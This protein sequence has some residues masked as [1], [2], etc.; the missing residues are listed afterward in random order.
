MY[1]GYVLT[2]FSS[3]GTFKLKVIICI[4]ILL[5]HYG[6]SIVDENIYTATWPRANIINVY[7]L[8]K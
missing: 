4:I 6:F 3:T 7:P 8:L 5:D 1:M 2:Y